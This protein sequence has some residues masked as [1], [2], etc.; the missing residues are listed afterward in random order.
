MFLFFLKSLWLIQLTISISVYFS[1]VWDYR[2]KD[3]FLHI[4]TSGGSWLILVLIDVYTIWIENY[5]P[6]HPK[7]LCMLIAFI[8][9]DFMLL[10][11][12]YDYVKPKYKEL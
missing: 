10:K 3:K 12:Y 7:A 1:I 2:K 8:L 5:D 11:M 4:L 6:T 9:G